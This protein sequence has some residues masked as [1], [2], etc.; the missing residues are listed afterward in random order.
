MCVYYNECDVLRIWWLV[1]KHPNETTCFT[2]EEKQT[3]PKPTEQV[4]NPRDYVSVFSKCTIN[5]NHQ[6]SAHKPLVCF[7]DRVVQI[8]FWQKGLLPEV[9]VQMFE[10][11]DKQR[12]EKIH[13]S[14]N[15]IANTQY[16]SYKLFILVCFILVVFAR[17]IYYISAII[18]MYRFKNH[19]IWSQCGQLGGQR[20]YE[21]KNLVRHRSLDS[22]Q[23]RKHIHA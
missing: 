8:F 4:A 12:D 3:K 20:E 21:K 9:C 13:H 23:F 15:C 6:Q 16:M 14:F 10:Q 7:I 19:Y 1:H 2:K 11:I 5:T 22:Q 18:F 17:L